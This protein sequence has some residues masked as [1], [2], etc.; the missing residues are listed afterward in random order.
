MDTQRTERLPQNFYGIFFDFLREHTLTE[1]VLGEDRLTMAPPPN[2]W[3]FKV[4][5]H[6]TC[7]F[8]F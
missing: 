6:V 1:A 5:P 7:V 3:F 2:I 4:N 8:M